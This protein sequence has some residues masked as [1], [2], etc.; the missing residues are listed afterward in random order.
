[1]STPD[2]QSLREDL[3]VEPRRPP[4]RRRRARRRRARRAQSQ[5]ET[6]FNWL[7]LLFLLAVG[8]PLLWFLSVHLLIPVAIFVFHVLSFLIKYS[9]WIIMILILLK[10]FDA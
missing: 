6:R 1:M 8:I 4:R 9:V 7:G 2:L 3:G 5:P 10:I